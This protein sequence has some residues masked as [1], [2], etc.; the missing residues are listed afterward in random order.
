MTSDTIDSAAP[1]HPSELRVLAGVCVAHWVS[2]FHLFVLPPLFPFLKQELGVSYV[3]LGF[4]L[5]V[6][7]IV[8]GLTQ[9][10][11]GFLV[12][13]V[14]ARRILMAGLCV[15]GA[16]FISLGFNLSYAGLLVCTALAGLANSVYHPSDYA[17]LS[18]SIRDQRIGRAFS[19]HTF[20]G[21]FGGAV[22]PA[23][24]L[25]LVSLF[26]APTALIVAGAVGPLAALLLVL[27]RVPEGGGTTK[28]AG[29][30]GGARAASVI[31]PA[32]LMLT[33]FFVLLS[34][35]NG[36]INGFSVA[37]FVKE[38]GLSLTSASLA[39]TAFLAASAI[40]VLAGGYLADRTERHG[41]VAAAC[42]TI[43]AALM[44]VVATT[45]PSAAV[46]VP[47][48]TLAG[49]FFGVIA[50]SR[51]MLV[52]KAAPPGAAGRAFG[53]VST[54]FNIGTMIGP[55]LY[56]AIMDRGAARWVFGVSVFFMLVTVALALLTEE[57]NRRK[58][59]HSAPA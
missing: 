10:P 4:A 53:I 26:G 24:I 30:P 36:G 33:L 55:L 12:D 59:T 29:K 5:T 1:E 8:S 34:L 42:F 14:G 32:I 43:S 48:M 23:I 58:S 46:L 44:L 6:L 40:G 35:S 31:N 11:M 54:G 56:G 18:A 37:A 28:L 19:V 50:P 57:R 16:A 3:E 7:G 2:H 38:Y 49:F 39:L 47:I 22:A 17:I 13:R 15:G 9:A 52:R 20:A 41:H 21:F 25:L 51:D 45:T 27:L